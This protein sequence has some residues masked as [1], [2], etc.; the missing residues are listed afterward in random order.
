MFSITNKWTVIAFDY[1]FMQRKTSHG[2]FFF[3]LSFLLNKQLCVDICYYKVWRLCLHLGKWSVL[4][5]KRVPC[6]PTWEQIMGSGEHARIT[7]G[8]I[9]SGEYEICV[10]GAW[11]EIKAFLLQKTGVFWCNYMFKCHNG[12]NFPCTVC[13]VIWTSACASTSVQRG[14]FIPG[15]S[16]WTSHLGIKQTY[17]YA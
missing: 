8:K 7:G 4:E 10:P 17:C 11:C 16:P 9:L 3:F 5:W 1:F 6:I 12:D 2:L 13:E 15:T 14:L